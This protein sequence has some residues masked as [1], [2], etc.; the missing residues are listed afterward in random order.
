MHLKK[1]S[2]KLRLIHSTVSSVDEFAHAFRAE[3]L[4][5]ILDQ[6]AQEAR[7]LTHDEYHQVLSLSKAFVV[8]ARPIFSGA[9]STYATSVDGVS[10]F[11][12]K[13]ANGL[14]PEYLAAQKGEVKR[15]FVFSSPRQATRHLNVLAAHHRQYGEVPNGGVFVASAE[16]YASFMNKIEAN[17]DLLLGDFAILRY[18]NPGGGD[19]VFYEARLTDDQ[20]SCSQLPRQLPHRYQAFIAEM[21]RLAHVKKGEF[22]SEASILR[23][24]PHFAQRDPTAEN[25]WKRC[26]VHLFQVHEG[27]EDEN[28][29]DRDVFHLV[30]FSRQAGTKSLDPKDIKTSA[31]N[32][33]R[34]VSEAVAELLKLRNKRD[35]SKPL[36]KELWF[37][38]FNEGLRRLEVRDGRFNGSITTGGFFVDNFPYCL[39]MRFENRTDLEDYYRDR[40]HSEARE[41]IF[42]C[43]DP[44]IIHLYDLAKSLRGTQ[45]QNAYQAIEGAASRFLVRGDYVE[46]EDLDWIVEKEDRILFGSNTSSDNSSG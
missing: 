42:T 32:L 10:A 20:L 30:F 14:A 45:Q 8:R 31:Q 13:E 17:S 24:D 38:D 29:R 21:D 11:W 16:T 19:E 18:P 3:H 37:G 34:A 9:R 33:R 43:C 26:L 1:A 12:E 5:E 27:G 36:V 7:K 44:D 40:T 35:R 15:L 22:D 46:H 23:F 28:M 4:T 41:R 6:S 25:D 2:Q 39:I